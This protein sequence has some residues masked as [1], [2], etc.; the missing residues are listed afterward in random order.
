M[1]RGCASEGLCR[2]E[3]SG[4]FPPCPDLHWELFHL[5]HLLITCPEMSRGVGLPHGHLTVSALTL[6]SP[7]ILTGPSGWHL[8]PEQMKRAVCLSCTATSE[9]TF[10][11]W[12]PCSVGCWGVLVPQAVAAKHEF[13]SLC[14]G[15]GPGGSESLSAVLGFLLFHGVFS[16]I[17]P[18]SRLP[19]HCSGAFPLCT[20]PP[21]IPLGAGYV[22]KRP[23]SLPLPHI[24]SFGDPFPGFLVS[25]VCFSLLPP[26]WVS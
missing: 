16:G 22:L 20:L 18:T 19:G 17:H 8:S 7:A 23:R 21:L 24:L 14:V 1:F 5:R 25:R 13:W 3:G 9:V 6:P 10:L 2:A 26:D 4:C 15:Q 12:L 11:A